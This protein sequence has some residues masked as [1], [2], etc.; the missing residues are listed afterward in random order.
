[1][2]IVESI[3]ANPCDRIDLSSVRGHLYL[4][5]VRALSSLPTN[6]KYIVSLEQVDSYP[7]HQQ[8]DTIFSCPIV[9]SRRGNYRFQKVWPRLCRIIHQHLQQGHSV[10]VHCRL[11]INRAPSLIVKYLMNYHGFNRHQAISIIR[12]H[13]PIALV[14]GYS[15]DL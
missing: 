1:M 15:Y 5:G 7:N 4:G 8:L 9:D 10:L 6:V 14:M 12:K 13:R 2:G 11:G 3:I